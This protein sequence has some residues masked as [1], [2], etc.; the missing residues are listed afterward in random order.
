MYNTDLTTGGHMFKI[1]TFNYGEK[2]LKSLEAVKGT[3]ELFVGKIDTEHGEKAA[4][5]D[6]DFSE[7]TTFGALNE[8]L[9]VT[10]IN[11]F[12]L[13]VDKTSSLRYP[14]RWINTRGSLLCIK[15]NL[16]G[17]STYHFMEVYDSNAAFFNI[18][19]RRIVGASFSNTDSNGPIEVFIFDYVKGIVTRVDVAYFCYESGALQ[20]YIDNLASP[21]TKLSRRLKGIK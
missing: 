8:I 18:D 6:T 2:E 20:N 10:M 17:G 19:S 14:G 5:L 11:P 3:S 9:N 13:V 21:N 1:H 12:L 4:V 16:T 7:V 15:G